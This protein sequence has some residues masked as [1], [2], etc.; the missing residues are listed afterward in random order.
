MAVVTSAQFYGKET[1]LLGVSA[2]IP[3]GVG[4]GGWNEAIFTTHESPWLAPSGITYVQYVE[5][6]FN[7][8][9]G[10]VPATLQWRFGNLATIA[11]AGDWKNS[12]VASTFP[13]NP[14]VYQSPD[15]G[16]I[17]GNGITFAARVQVAGTGVQTAVIKAYGWC[18]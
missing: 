18:L 16:P 11:T 3:I 17:Y 2:P 6:I 10:A 15:P 12:F 9:E 14:S 5:A 8:G 4:T 13:V 1:V 7:D